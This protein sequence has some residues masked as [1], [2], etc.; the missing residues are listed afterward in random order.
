MLIFDPS[1]RITA[2]EALLH[3]YFSEYG[4][5]RNNSTGNNLTTT[6]LSTDIPDQT[7][8][9]VSS[10]NRNRAE[11]DSSSVNSPNSRSSLIH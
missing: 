2:S 7:V 9:L 4:L 11:A 6:T 5:T 10:P 8:N 1:N 3:P